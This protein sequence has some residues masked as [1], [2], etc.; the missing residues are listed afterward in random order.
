MINFLGRIIK[1]FMKRPIFTSALRP[2]VQTPQMVNIIKECVPCQRACSELKTLNS[3]TSCLSHE[4][5]QLGLKECQK[6]QGH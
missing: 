2:L 4:A 6:S 1:T 5:S 3:L